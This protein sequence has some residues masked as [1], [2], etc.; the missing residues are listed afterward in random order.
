MAVTV[1]V[2]PEHLPDQ[3]A[4]TCGTCGQDWPCDPARERAKLEH[5]DDPVGLSVYFG[6]LLGIAAAEIPSRVTPGELFDR[7]I[8][9]TRPQPLDV[10]DSPDSALSSPRK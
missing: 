7:F 8:A 3:P 6:A 5:R 1:P 10:R 2:V 4:W 9:W